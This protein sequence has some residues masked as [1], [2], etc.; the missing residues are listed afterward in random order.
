MGRWIDYGLGGLGGFYGSRDYEPPWESPVKKKCEAIVEK[1]L[2][3][4][5][6][7]AALKDYQAAYDKQIYVDYQRVADEAK[8]RM[9]HPHH[10]LHEMYHTGQYGRP[11][12]NSCPWCAAKR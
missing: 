2:A 11:A 7:A 1:A 5:K 3:R 8:R 12:P 9:D 6:Y 10:V 4:E